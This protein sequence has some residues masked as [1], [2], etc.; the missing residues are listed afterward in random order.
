MKLVIPTNFSEDYFDKID[1]S[2]TEEIYGKMNIDLI[3]GGRAAFTLP[4]VKKEQVVKFVNETH[5]RGMKFNYLLNG[6]CF[7][8]LEVSKKGYGKIRKQLDWLSEIGVDVVTVSLPMLLEIV[9]KHYPN[10]S[11]SVSIQVVINNLERAKYWEGLGADKL[12]IS[13]VDINKDFVELR[14][15]RKAVSCKIQTIANL[16]CMNRCPF[17]T[18]HANYNAHTS[19]GDHCTNH[20]G[21]D[22]YLSNCASKLLSDPVE[23]LKSAFIRPEDIH[24]YEEEGVDNMKL[25]E[26]SMTTEHLSTIISAYTKR[27]YDGNMMDLIHGFSKYVIYKK[28]ESFL[29]GKQH[30][31]QPSHVN[32]F[33]L[34]GMLYELI[35]L[36]KKKEFNESFDLYIDNKKLD[37][38]M[39]LFYKH[40]CPRNCST[41]TYCGDFAEKAVSLLV[42]VQEHNK[43]MELFKRSKQVLI[44]GDLF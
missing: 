35:Q 14:K 22:Y 3:G 6:T 16:I 39:D 1:F 7:D 28:G 24:Y 8:N 31:F 36:K 19:Q 12:N 11:A 15:I 13:Y 9:K 29:K 30:L 17:V 42:P 27:E 37:G 43:N 40:S 18:L 2:A 38:F 21:L 41:C 25:V 34:G 44:N 32:V 33:K 4:P 20:F 10:F 23:I 26:R 5:K